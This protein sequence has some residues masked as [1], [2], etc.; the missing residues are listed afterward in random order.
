MSFE[1]VVQIMEEA[2]S[3]YLAT[4]DGERPGVRP[5][6]C[7]QWIDGELW[8]ATHIGSAKV[9]DVRK[10]ARVEFCIADQN[11]R[12]VRISGRCRVSTDKADRQAF[13]DRVPV[14]KEYFDGVDDP[15]YAILRV[16]VDDI[17]LMTNEGETHVAVPSS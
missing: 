8:L 7:P 6:G 4:T 1:T 12:Y 5:M 17:R 11:W 13:L 3:G 15:G 14:V 2:K 10:K 16:A 9:A